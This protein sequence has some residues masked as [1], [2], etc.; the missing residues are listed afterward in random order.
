[1]TKWIVNIIEAERG[2]GR[3]IDEQRTFSSF[4]EAK[5]FAK[6][7]NSKLEALA[8]NGRAPDWYMQ[9]EGPYECP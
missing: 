4:E 2:W 5:A 8:Q 7:Y 1:M 3:K 9:A 6:E